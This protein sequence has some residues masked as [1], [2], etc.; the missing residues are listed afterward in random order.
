MMHRGTTV[1]GDKSSSLLSRLSRTIGSWLLVSWWCCTVTTCVADSRDFDDYRFDG[2]LC[3]YYQL[4]E[5]G[6]RSYYLYSPGYPD[7]YLADDQDRE[8]RWFAKTPSPA[9]RLVLDCHEFDLPESSFCESDALIVSRVGD[10]NFTDGVRHC[11]PRSFTAISRTNKMN[12]KFVAK[13]QSRSGR[14]MCSVGA[15]RVDFWIPETVTNPQFCECGEQD[16]GVFANPKTAGVKEYPLIASLIDGQSANLFCGATIISRHHALTSASCLT[17]VNPFQIALLVGDHDMTSIGSDGDPS[18]LV[19]VTE[20][21]IHPL[22]DQS[23]VTHDLAIVETHEVIPFSS[24]VGPACLPFKHVYD[25]FV[26]DTIRVLGW[27]TVNFDDHP[28]SGTLQKSHLKVVPTSQCVEKYKNETDR[29]QLCAHFTKVNSYCQVDSGGPLLWSDPSTGRL[30]IIGVVS[31][32]FAC[33]ESTPSMHTRLTTV[34]NINWI[35]VIL[36]GQ[37]Y[38]S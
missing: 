6:N 7:P 27:G 4:I 33:D 2:G 9:D 30:N 12:I 11:G 20:I 14:F 25:D 32:R 15:K 22:F 19:V 21:Y 28:V 38:C 17:N 18:L 36:T 24:K 29:N 35:K 16:Q 34:K 3:E 23:S 13:R 10:T 1:G 31:N 37:Y 5:P 8:C 26:G